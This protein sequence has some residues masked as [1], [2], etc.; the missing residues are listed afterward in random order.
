MGIKWLNELIDDYIEARS[1]PG[2]LVKRKYLLK[3]R[4]YYKNNSNSIEHLELEEVLTRAAWAKDYNGNRHSH[5]RRLKK[6]VLEQINTLFSDRKG[7]FKNCSSFEDI[8][9]IVSECRIKGFGPLAIY[10]AS[11]RISVYLDL[12]PTQVHLHAGVRTGA[13]SL[14]LDISKGYITVELLPDEFKKL[15]VCEIEDFL[16][17]YKYKIVECGNEN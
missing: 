17:I 13:Q 16:C 6:K 5:Q 10:D 1:E 15:E 4:E 3:L 7:D 12:L 9:K 11:F 2:K 8:F 14:G